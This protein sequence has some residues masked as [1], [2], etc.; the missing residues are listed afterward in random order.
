MSMGERGEQRECNAC[1]EVMDIDD[2]DDLCVDCWE[3]A[4][5]NGNMGEE[6]MEG[7]G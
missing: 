2:P 3:E 7:E 6:E 5:E 1:G 4:A